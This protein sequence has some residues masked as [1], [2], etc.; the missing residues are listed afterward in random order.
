MKSGSVLQ[1]VPSGQEVERRLP[2]TGR[3][4]RV[5]VEGRAWVDWPGSG[6]EH[7][8]R[9]AHAVAHDV[10]REA[11]KRSAEVLL[12]AD[13]DQRPVIVDLIRDR[14]TSGSKR[15]VESCENS[16]VVPEL[17]KPPAVLVDGQRVTIEGHDEIVLRCGGASITLRR[18]GRVV[19]RGVYVET[20]SSGV[21]RIRGGSVRI[22]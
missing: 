1:V 5:D 10:L 14:V 15:A 13:A 8:A 12:A 6:G 21:N 4:V 11:L 18:N 19:I 3:L 20:R 17:E 7:L 22:N 2:A 9:V 16:I